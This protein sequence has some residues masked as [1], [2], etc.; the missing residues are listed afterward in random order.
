MFLRFIFTKVGV[1]AAACGQAV[2]LVHAQVP[3]AHHVRGVPRLLHQLGQ[4]LLLQRDAGRLTGPDDLVLH[5]RVDLSRTKQRHVVRKYDCD[6]N[7][8]RVK[9]EAAASVWT[10]MKLKG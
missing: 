1:K 5:A 8:T 7:A 9:E 2:L 6:E 3:L 4:Q 10:V